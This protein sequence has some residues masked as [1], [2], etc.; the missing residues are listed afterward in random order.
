M[1]LFNVDPGLALWTWISFGVLFYILSRYALPKAFASLKE[2]EKLIAKSVDDAHEVE[3]RLSESQKEREIVLRNARSEGEAI[4]RQAR[5][6]AAELSRELTN[7]A[8]VE[9]NAI[10]VRANERIEEERRAAIRTLTDDLSVFVC[11]ASERIIGKAFVGEEERAWTREL[12][13]KL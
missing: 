3:I 5:E 1:S 11:D 6:Y 13:E 4:I 2:R 9:A 10:I 8:E 12:V 7:K